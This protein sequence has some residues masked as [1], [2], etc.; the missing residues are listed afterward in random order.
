MT[1]GGFGGSCIAIVRASD[2][3]D[4]AAA[5]TAAFDSEGFTPPA[6]FTVTASGPADRDR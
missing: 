6:S 5:I 2:A 3:A 4:V 1:G